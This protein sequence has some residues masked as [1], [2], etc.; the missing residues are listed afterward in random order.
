MTIIRWHEVGSRRPALIIEIDMVI[1]RR[2]A[3]WEHRPFHS[4]AEARAHHQ[5]WYAGGKRIVQPS[6]DFR[7]RA[8][9]RVNGEESGVFEVGCF[10]NAQGKRKRNLATTTVSSYGE[11]GK[12]GRYRC[13]EGVFQ[14]IGEPV[15][16]IDGGVYLICEADIHAPYGVELWRKRSMSLVAWMLRRVHNK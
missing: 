4:V 5:D 14:A 2:S 10:A 13:G 6:K 1:F 12:I 7:C 8:F 3:G 9:D 16:D 15:D 11:F